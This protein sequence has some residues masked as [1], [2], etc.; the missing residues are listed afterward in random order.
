[1]QE[2]SE[3]L[4]QEA[5]EKEKSLTERQDLAKLEDELKLVEIRKSEVEACEIV[6][7]TKTEDHGISY[8]FF[9]RFHHFF[10]EILSMFH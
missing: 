9:W 6:G 2:K 10:L 1:M 7:S 8:V 5:V 3:E 4:K